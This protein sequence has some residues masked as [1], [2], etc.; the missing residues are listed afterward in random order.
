VDQPKQSIFEST[1]FYSF[2]ETIPNTRNTSIRINTF[3]INQSMANDS[4][5]LLVNSKVP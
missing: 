3:D 4:S 1:D 5:T 2:L